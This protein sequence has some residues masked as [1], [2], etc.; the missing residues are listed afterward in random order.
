MG[1]VCGTYGNHVPSLLEIRIFA[2]GVVHGFLRGSVNVATAVH[3]SG[4]APNGHA[5]RNREG[6]LSR[7]KA[8]LI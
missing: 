3:E 8:D 2:Q 5:R 6:R 4:L 1:R 7:G